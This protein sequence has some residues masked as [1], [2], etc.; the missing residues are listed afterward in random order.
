[1]HRDH[2][3][4]ILTQAL[5]ILV[6][7][8]I[9]PNDNISAKLHT[10]ACRHYGQRRPGYETYSDA[11][12]RALLKVEPERYLDKCLASQYT[13]SQAKALSYLK[14]V[15]LASTSA[16]PARY[17]GTLQ[18]M[19][20]NSDA[21]VA[22][23]VH[24][25]NILAN[26]EDINF[27]VEHFGSLEHLYR[28]APTPALRQALLPLLAKSANSGLVNSGSRSFVRDAICQLGC[29]ESSAARHAACLAMSLMHCWR[30]DDSF[31]FHRQLLRFLQDDDIDIRRSASS[32]TSGL[33]TQHQPLCTSRAIELVWHFCKTVA[34]G[35]DAQTLLQELGEGLEVA[36]EAAEAGSH[37]LFAVERSNMH[38]DITLDLDH[39][40]QII[41]Q[42]GLKTEDV[43]GVSA[44]VSS[45]QDRLQQLIDTVA[46]V[47]AA[48]SHEVQK[49]Y[50]FM[51]ARLLLQKLL[52]VLE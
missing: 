19:L 10:L 11:L 42:A 36:T 15:S 31:D 41:T 9:P 2:A 21:A 3:L 40:L 14:A 18:K 38:L 49:A 17:S 50:T 28:K 43:K 4:P 30:A 23:R 29:D 34:S 6:L 25:A 47:N 16:R 26:S 20:R 35:S 1:M 7:S 13:S 33:L 52:Q 46:S 44:I 22:N 48:E 45:C 24:A 39:Q 27:T 8:P 51:Q 5:E 37:M 12:T 32:I